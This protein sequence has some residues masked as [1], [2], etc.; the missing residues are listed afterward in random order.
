[1]DLTNVAIVRE[2]LDYNLFSQFLS[3]ILVIG[4]FVAAL[5]FFKFMICPR[6]R[7]TQYYRKVLMDLFVVGK[8]KE[9]AKEGKINLAK[10][11]ADFNNWT[12]KR[13][14]TDVDLDNVI[15]EEIKEKI[16]EEV[17]SEQEE[18]EQKEPEQKEPKQKVPKEKK[19]K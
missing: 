14:L 4:V 2:I 12:R 7:P 19:T 18:P 15:E 13:R 17:V 6:L 10:E 5:W 3:A 1:M 9:F 8:I 16:S 11:E